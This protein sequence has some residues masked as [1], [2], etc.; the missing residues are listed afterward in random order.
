MK[1]HISSRLKSL[2]AHNRLA[3]FRFMERRCHLGNRYME[4]SIAETSELIGYTREG[5]TGLDPALLPMECPE[6]C[7]G[8]Y[9]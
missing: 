8:F 2:Y 3:W 6:I 1:K 9:L 7:A 4:M 5:Q